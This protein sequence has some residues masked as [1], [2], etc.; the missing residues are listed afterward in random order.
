MYY[1][2]KRMWY[3]FLRLIGLRPGSAL[4][5]SEERPS[6]TVGPRRTVSSYVSPPDDGDTGSRE[7]VARTFGP[8]VT[9]TK[10][11]SPP[12]DAFEVS[13]QDTRSDG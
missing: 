1:R 5:R 2:V 9:L 4:R 11:T 6:R 7:R 10:Y 12:D 8:P 3:A 13:R